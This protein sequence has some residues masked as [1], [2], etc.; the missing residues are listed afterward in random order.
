MY[1]YFYTQFLIK[2]VQHNL[3]YFIL[4]SHRRTAGYRSSDPE[5]TDEIFSLLSTISS[6]FT[7]YDKIHR[8]LFQFAFEAL[9]YDT[10]SNAIKVAIFIEKL[11]RLGNFYVP[12]LSDDSLNQLLQLIWAIFKE[13]VFTSFK[14]S[15]SVQ[16]LFQVCLETRVNDNNLIKFLREC[17][18]RF[19]LCDS[20]DNGRAV[21]CALFFLSTFTANDPRIHTL[22]AEGF[23]NVLEGELCRFLSSKRSLLFSGICDEISYKLEI[24]NRLKLLQFFYTVSDDIRLHEESLQRIWSLFQLP[25]EREEAIY[26]FGNVGSLSG[27]LRIGAAFDSRTS[28]TVFRSMICDSSVDWSQYGTESFNSF[29]LYFENLANYTDLNVQ[30]AAMD[31]GLETLWRITLSSNNQE[32]SNLATTLLLRT[33]RAFSSTRKDYEQELVT[34]IFS[35]IEKIQ[36]EVTESGAGALSSLHVASL[37]R[38]ISILREVAVRSK[39]SLVPTH[40]A[41]GSHSY[42]AVDIKWK[43]RPDTYQSSNY[44]SVNHNISSLS[45]GEGICRVQVSPF[46]TVYQLKEKIARVANFKPS[47]NVLLQLK[48]KYIVNES[49]V[50]GHYGLAAGWPIVASYN[51]HSKFVA[52]D[53]DNIFPAAGEV[54]AFDKSKFDILVSLLD[55]TEEVHDELASIIWDF[56]MISPTQSDLRNLLSSFE[57]SDNRSP[58]ELLGSVSL[59]TTTYTLQIIDNLLQPFLEDENEAF[60]QDTSNFKQKFIA[61]SGFKIVLGIFL[62]TPICSRRLVNITLSTSLHIIHFLLRNEN[63]DNVSPVSP[64]TN[65][66][67]PLYASIAVASATVVNKL[68]EIGTNAADLGQSDVV[69][70]A[71]SVITML[72]RSPDAAAQL[73]ANPH[74]KSLLS[75]VLKSGSEKVR[76]MASDFA[77]QVGKSQPI[78]FDWLVGEVELT[79]PSSKSCIELFRSLALLITNFVSAGVNVSFDK[80]AS[81]LSNK[82][83]SFSQDNSGAS[84][85]RLMLLGCLQTQRLLIENKVGA[86]IN[87]DF[88][89]QL[90]SVSFSRFLFSLPTAKYDVAAICDTDD[91]RKAA[92]SLLLTQ[93]SDNDIPVIIDEI[94][95]L[96]LGFV[97]MRGRWNQQMSHE[98]KKDNIEFSGLKNQGCTCYMNSLLQQL[99]MT[100]GFRD[101]VLDASIRDSHRS[102]LWHK[103]D[104]E[105]V[106]SEFLFHWTNGSWNKGTII[107]LV[108]GRHRVQYDTD[109]ESKSCV[110]NVRIGRLG[111]E[112]GFV[113]HILPPEEQE[114]ERLTDSDRAALFVLEQLQ[115]TFCFMKF[116]KQ[117]YFD[118]R[119]F[120]EACKTLNLNFDV[121]QQNDAAEFCDQLLDRLET[122]MKGKYNGLNSWDDCMLKTVFGGK[123]FRTKRLNF[124][125]GIG[126][127]QS[128]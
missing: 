23:H 104:E 97:R 54:V 90:F 86:A 5:I 85:E 91:A 117:R 27:S 45:H 4:F 29:Q 69:H 63:I 106:G 92:F 61:A 77:S 123:S 105:L 110:F 22:Y 99:F 122:S 32:V 17:G 36:T 119:P 43:R 67:C 35:E 20:K 37:T 13:T 103:T 83:M 82:L 100:P 51:Y 74:A 125:W 24:R 107:G 46:T 34:R 95:S 52:V 62:S 14:C 127:F 81:V 87:S 64:S 108:N 16:K 41:S 15:L 96:S 68:L 44:C 6:N 121:F 112:T 98:V 30:T 33:Y 50:L 75:V 47:S 71:L 66:R 113:R 38:C 59:A 118:P 109:A 84:T 25:C 89:K 114:Q 72:L 12:S 93:M 7:V 57:V 58:L 10:G 78:V 120:V 3:I 2:A 40:G 48:D 42:I 124:S 65:E 49:A 39:G 31:A 60:L 26:F 115:R 76:G 11:E 19:A 8:E 116:S 53:S 79:A 56:L 80:L 1:I 21:D 101:A 126:A 9:E 88:G 55:L 111:I 94:S 73:T 128:C 18:Q 28:S 70:D 102:T